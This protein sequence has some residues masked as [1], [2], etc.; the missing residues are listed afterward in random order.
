MYF[1]GQ[2]SPCRMK[3]IFRVGQ[4]HIYMRCIYVFFGREITKYTVIYGVYLRFWP[5]LRIFNRV[6]REQRGQALLTHQSPG[7][8]RYTSKGSKVCSCHNSSTKYP[9]IYV[10]SRSCPNICLQSQGHVWMLMS[11]KK[12]DRCLQV[13]FNTIT[14]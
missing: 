3:R 13:P 1:I 14:L 11:N 6:Q 4:N 5:T 7:K 12:Q 9:V 2:S 8:W 10:H